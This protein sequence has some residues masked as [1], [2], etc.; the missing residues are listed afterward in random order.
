MDGR[1]AKRKSHETSN[2]SSWEITSYRLTGRVWM[3]SIQL[4]LKSS[5]K[6]P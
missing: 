5:E 6:I 2:R 4:S 1:A 3:N